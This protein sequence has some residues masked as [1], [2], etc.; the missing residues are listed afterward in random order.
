[1]RF[2]FV[3]TRGSSLGKGQQLYM[4]LGVQTLGQSVSCGS[5]TSK[6]YTVVTKSIGHY[7]FLSTQ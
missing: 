7:S 1:M 6:R 2:R 5:I 4:F 3:G